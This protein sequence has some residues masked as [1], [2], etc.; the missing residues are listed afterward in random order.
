MPNFQISDNERYFIAVSSKCRES[1]KFTVA[2]GTNNS[3]ATDVGC[4]DLYQLMGRNPTITGILAR[5]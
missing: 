2:T 5:P 1:V 3:R 4:N